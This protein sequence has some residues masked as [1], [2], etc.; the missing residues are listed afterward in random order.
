MTKLKKEIKAFGVFS[1]ASGAMISSGIFIL[2]GLAFTKVG[3]GLYISYLLAGFLGLVGILSMI[4]L[5]TAMP[6][7]GGDYY[8]INRSFGP[9]IG[10]ISGFLGWFALTLKSSFAVFGI[11]QIIFTKSEVQG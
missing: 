10:S 2:P 4:E 8:Y 6:K 9:L 7:A 1:I 3:S 11:S 5:A